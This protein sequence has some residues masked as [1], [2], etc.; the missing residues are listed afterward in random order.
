M[1]KQELRALI[2][3]KRAKISPEEKKQRDAAIRARI[4][5][6]PVFLEASS[7]L[8]YAPR[9]QEINLLPLCRAA[10]ERGIPVGFPRCDTA[11]STLQFCC[12]EPNGRLVKGAYGIY[13]PPIDAPPCPIDAHTLCI[14]PGLTFDP[15]GGRLGYGKG[16]YD[17][18]LATFPGVRAA[19]IYESL[20]VKHVPTEP[21][22]RPVALLFTEHECWDCRKAPPAPPKKARFSLKRALRPAAERLYN[23]LSKKQEQ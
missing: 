2:K 1:T 10:W 6:S 7:L 8:I 5:A 22:D 17:R 12:L 14:L 3:E 15:T 13:E 9:E 20:L 19:A 16:Y 21:H 4:L 18:F 11:T 23:Y